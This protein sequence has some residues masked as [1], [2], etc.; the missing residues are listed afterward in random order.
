MINSISIL[1]TQSPEMTMSS[2]EIAQ[3]TGKRHDNVLRDIREMFP[4]LGKGFG[5]E[6]SSSYKDSAGRTQPSYELPKRECMNLI[7]CYNKSLRYVVLDRWQEK[8]EEVVKPQSDV[9]TLLAQLEAGLEAY[10]KL[11]ALGRLP[12]G[13]A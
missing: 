1:A 8:M 6:F 4:R 9:D 11:A 3:L 13:W 10:N 5:F 7:A 2:L 12:A